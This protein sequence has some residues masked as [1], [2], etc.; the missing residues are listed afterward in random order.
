MYYGKKSHLNYFIRI[1]GTD[2]KLY[3]KNHL[4]LTLNLKSSSAHPSGQS[5]SCKIQSEN[6]FQKA[7]NNEKDFIIFNLSKG[8]LI[9]F[10][11]KDLGLPYFRE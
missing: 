1:G 7:S 9:P 10:A 4:K 11:K 5:S 3:T 2:S 6:F 8:R